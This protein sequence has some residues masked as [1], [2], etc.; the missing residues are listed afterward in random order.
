MRTPTI[1][2]I[3]ESEQGVTRNG[4]P[5]TTHVEDLQGAKGANFRFIS[6]L[7]SRGHRQ[8]G[9]TTGRLEKAIRQDDTAALKK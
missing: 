7:T 6:P 3:T 1:R 5:A 2:R 9:T 8:H 4:K